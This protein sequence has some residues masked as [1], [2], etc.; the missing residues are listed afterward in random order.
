MGTLWIREDAKGWEG[1]ISPEVVARGEVL[2]RMVERRVGPVGELTPADRPNVI[3]SIQPIDRTVAEDENWTLTVRRGETVSARVIVRRKEKFTNEISFGKENS[4]RNTAH[5][6]YVDNIGL[7]GLLVR[8]NEDER[9][10]SLTADPITKPGKRSFF[11]TGGV[12]GGVTTHPIT[13]EVL[14]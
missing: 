6:V 7:N 13:V 5:G 8:A 9:E 2:G 12:D 1:K 10:F 4:G 11:L 3:P 14:P